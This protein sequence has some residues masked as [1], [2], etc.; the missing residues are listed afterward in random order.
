MNG[1]DR[2]Y[3]FHDTRD[4]GKYEAALAKLRKCPVYTDDPRLQDYVENV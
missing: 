1:I 3:S 2:L 4:Q